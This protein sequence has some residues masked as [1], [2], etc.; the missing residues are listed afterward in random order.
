MDK[1]N[2]TNMKHLVKILFVI[3]L[4]RFNTIQPHKM[5]QKVNDMNVYSNLILWINSFLTG[6]SQY[7]KYLYEKS[8]NHNTGKQQGCGHL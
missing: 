5:M 6:R 7:R 2:A 1:P 4:V 8:D 3:F